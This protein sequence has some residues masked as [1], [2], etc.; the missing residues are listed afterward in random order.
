MRDLNRPKGENEKRV[1]RRDVHP[2]RIVVVRSWVGEGWRSVQVR[3]CETD[4]GVPVRRLRVREN[5]ANSRTTRVSSFNSC[6]GYKNEKGTHIW[7]DAPY[8]R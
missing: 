4:E 3:I 5:G 7:M 8:S 6:Y 2:V 1:R